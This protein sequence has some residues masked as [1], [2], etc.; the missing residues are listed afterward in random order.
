M[1]NPCD[2]KYDLSR[3]PSW[4]PSRLLTLQVG[5]SHAYGMNTPESDVDFRG[6]CVP[7]M[8]FY[9]DPFKNFEQFETHHPDVT[10]FSISKFFRLAAECNPNIIEILF[11]DAKSEYP[12]WSLPESDL[13]AALEWA[14]LLIKKNRK[15]FLSSR[16]AYS[17]SGYAMAQLKRIKTH[18]FWLLNPPTHRPTRGEFGLSDLNG[19]SR[20]TL[21]VIR[22]SK[23]PENQF[24]SEV[25]ELY[26]KE[27][28]YLN[29]MAH[30]DQY[31]HWL[32]TRNPVRA[33][34]ERIYGYDTKHGAHLV[35]LM[36]MGEE[37]LTTGEV[38][39]MRPDAEELLAI[40]NGAWSYE[41]ITEWAW[42]MD[43]KVQALS[44]TTSLPHS[45]ENIGQL[46]AL[47]QNIIEVVN[48]PRTAASTVNRW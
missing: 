48:A 37:I 15:L 40:R 39:V 9:L 19:M 14:W 27:Q 4:L 42:E 43:G 6:I 3:A 26:R 2:I 33:E 29:A 31:Q 5:G 41:K 32:N 28:S 36:R 35:R 17:F 18:R 44:K 45:K 25:M 38:N 34:N 46:G 24:A 8:E 20:S 23:D 12:R 11:V 10:I 13:S 1:N 21:G 30:W 7:P 47:H 16:A 22:G